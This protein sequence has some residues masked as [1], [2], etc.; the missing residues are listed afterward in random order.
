ML[1][2]LVDFFSGLSWMSDW[3]ANVLSVSLI[4]CGI[5]AAAV[6]IYALM[7]HFFQQW[8]NRWIQKTNNKWD[9]AFM[10][11]GVFRRILRLFPLFLVYVGV[12]RMLVSSGSSIMLSRVVYALMIVSVGR[13]I[14]ALLDSAGRVYRMMDL[15]DRRPITGYLQAVTILLYLFVSIF[16]LA[17]LLGKSPWGLLSVLGGLT[18]VLLL[19]FKDT[20]LGFVAGVQLGAH[21][22]VR[23]GDWIEMPKYGADGDVVAL[24]VNTVK[25]QNWDKTISTIP[26][27]AMISDSFKNWR[28]MSESGGRRIKRSIHLDMNSI[29]FLDDAMLARFREFDLLSAY[30]TDKQNEIDAENESKSVN[31]NLRVN[32][33]RQTN[34]GVFRAYLEQF[35]ST[36]P[37]IHDEMTFLV[38]Q[39]QPTAQGLPIEIYVFSKD[40]A[41]ANYEAIQADIF[42]HVLAAIPEFDL[43]VF[44]SPS[45][46]DFQGFI[47]KAHPEGL[48]K[49]QE[50]A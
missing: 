23:V 27:Y 37:L 45:G 22:M 12:E 19:V 1:N 30:V 47:L 32:G 15:K 35:L 34:A 41:W 14:Q 18:A 17:T 25:V 11:A 31:L 39:L 33:R 42:D 16:T 8:I 9:D 24:T 40:Q 13:V 7:Y 36:H 48:V 3:V 4:L 20:I 10:E 28:G 50:E 49:T 5:F 44:Q 26:T 38:R 6:A 43:R 21:D 2:Q 29:R 46:V